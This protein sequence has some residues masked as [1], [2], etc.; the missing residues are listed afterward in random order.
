MKLLSQVKKNRQQ[1]NKQ[2]D[3]EKDTNK[4]TNIDIHR[5]TSKKT[6]ILNKEKAGHNK[7]KQTSVI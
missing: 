4:V 3:I 6:C 1:D 5:Q 2:T 7:F